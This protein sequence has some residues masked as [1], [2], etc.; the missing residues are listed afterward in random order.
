MRIKAREV[1]RLSRR[2]GLRST[3]DRGFYLPNTGIATRAIQQC[4]GH[5]SMQHPVCYT[6]LIP[7]RLPTFGRSDAGP[8][9]SK[10]CLYGTIVPFHLSHDD[11]SA[12][13]DARMGA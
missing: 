2:L 7:H 4:V 13:I 5:R 3:S 12:Q 9:R 8:F 10:P 6:A 11:L 1:R